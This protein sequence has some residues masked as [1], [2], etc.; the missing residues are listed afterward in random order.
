[1][2][3]V[4]N[5]KSNLDK[6]EF[7]TYQDNLRDIASSNKLVLCPTFLNISQ[8][9]LSNFSLGSQNVSSTNNGPYTGEVSSVQLK[10]FKV[11]YTIIGHSERRYLLNENNTDILN[12]LERLLE[13]D[14]TPI[15][16]IGETKE[17]RENNKVLETLNKELSVLDN[18]SN[19]NIIIAYEP[20][21]SIGTNTIPTPNQ[22]EEVFS[23]IKKKL[24][25][26]KVLYGGSVNEENINELKLEFIDG[27]LLGGISLHPDK[28]KLLLSKLDN[29]N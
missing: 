5:N 9:N 28:L 13:Q 14:I 16:C 17:E 10:S 19:S 7:I 22:L 20:I 23:F 25:N 21:W 1:M 15:L 29:T 4:L 26:N 12:K 2:I 6:D 24:P 18:I 11:E 8:F 27:Y 3:I